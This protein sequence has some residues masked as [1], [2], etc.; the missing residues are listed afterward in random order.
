MIY[1]KDDL[2]PYKSET[3]GVDQH[4]NDDEDWDDDTV[5]KVLKEAR[6]YAELNPSTEKEQDNKTLC[7]KQEVLVGLY[8]K[9]MFHNHLPAGTDSGNPVRLEGCFDCEF[10]GKQHCDVNIDDPVVTGYLGDCG[11]DILIVGEAPSN[12]GKT[13]RLPVLSLPCPS[14]WSNVLLPGRTSFLEGARDNLYTPRPGNSPLGLIEYIRNTKGNG[15]YP[16]FSDLIKCGVHVQNGTRKKD[17]DKREQYCV[18]HILWNEIQ[19]IQPKYILCCHERAFQSVSALLKRN[20]WN[21]NT[22]V[23]RV[24]HYCNAN[25][26]KESI[27]VDSIWP[28]Q[29][30]FS[31]PVDPNPIKRYTVKKRWITFP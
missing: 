29:T 9:K 26:I 10:K 11:S 15:L 27:K 2:R 28:I 19:I 3:V 24:C 23:V 12:S 4:F 8:S 16:Y 13:A 1:N 31:L 18:D 5:E 22:T 25:C 21:R 20:N 30:G 14:P 17:L 6:E 7:L